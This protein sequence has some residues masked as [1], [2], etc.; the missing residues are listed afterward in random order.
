MMNIT[1]K[2]HNL[3]EKYYENRQKKRNIV[4]IE[5]VKRLQNALTYRGSTR[6]S[7]NVQHVRSLSLIYFLKSTLI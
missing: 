5:K 4:Q 7:S 2:S 3:Y 1:L 6:S